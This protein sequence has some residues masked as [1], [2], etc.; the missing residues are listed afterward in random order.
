MPAFPLLSAPPATAPPANNYPTYARVQYVEECMRGS[1]GG[2]MAGLYQCSC[3]IDHI[4]E[5]LTYDEFVEASTFAHNATLPG[6]GGGIFRDPDRAKQQAK[7][8]R[9]LE[10]EA[11]R[12]CGLK[13]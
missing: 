10:A 6:E 9:D 4:A 13:T 12:V 11:Y 7:L 8:Y 1:H 3:A 5:H 2:A